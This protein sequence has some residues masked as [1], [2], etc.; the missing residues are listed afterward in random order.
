MRFF[1]LAL[2]VLNGCGPKLQVALWQDRAGQYVAT[3][4]C[5]AGSQQEEAEVRSAARL[6]PHTPTEAE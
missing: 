2:A 4:R 1:L 5:S 3:M 6:V